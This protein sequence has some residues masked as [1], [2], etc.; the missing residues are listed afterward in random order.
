MC[1]LIPLFL[2][3]LRYLRNE[4]RQSNKDNYP[5]LH[6]PEIYLLEGG[7]KA[8]YEKYKVS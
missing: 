5:S 7:Y 2:F 8:F 4:D 6:H 3:R 1:D